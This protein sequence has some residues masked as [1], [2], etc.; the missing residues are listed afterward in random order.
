MCVHEAN[1]DVISLEICQVLKR[2]NTIKVLY[3]TI[4]ILSTASSKR[5]HYFVI[6]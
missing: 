1:Y 5:K 3:H 2:H 4:E 6:K